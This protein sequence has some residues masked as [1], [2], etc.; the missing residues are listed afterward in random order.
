MFRVPC[1]SGVVGLAM[2]LAAASPAAAQ[3][4]VP[5]F[6]ARTAVYVEAGGNAGIA[7]INVDRM[8]LD[9]VSLRVG[10]M[11]VTVGLA[12]GVVMP[13]TAQYLIGGG[14]N[15]L[16]IGGGATLLAGE[17]DLEVFDAEDSG[18]TLV[19]TGTIGYRFQR[20]AGGAVF[21]VTLNPI[22]LD[23]EPVF[24]GG[25]SFGYSF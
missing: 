21:R 17:Y 3:D 16:E 9:G 22:F 4:D 10:V 14:S 12:S 7:S 2:V 20:P 5:V 18:T 24:W 13:M 23:S 11:P 8:V 6:H 25:L 15:F 19:P 1:C